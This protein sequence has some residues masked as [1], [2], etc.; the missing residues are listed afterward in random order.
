M[1]R[2]LEVESA[3]ITE[4]SSQPE[5]VSDFELTNPSSFKGEFI[6]QITHN[7][8]HTLS[9]SRSN[10]GEL[11]VGQ[12]LTYKVEA[13]GSGVGGETSVRFAANWSKETVTT[14]S[15]NLGTLGRV[16]V[17]LEPGQSVIA[18]LS[19]SAGTIKARVRYKAF[20]KGDTLVHY[21]Q[22]YNGHY[23]WFRNIQ[24]PMYVANIEN[25]IE[26]VEDIEIGY[27]S[28]FVVRL[29][30][31]KSGDL[32][33]AIDMTDIPANSFFNDTSSPIDKSPVID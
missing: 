11:E 10:G 24:I 33:Q 32:M 27:Y 13:L 18:Q 21:D 4:I 12:K 30:D 16:Q 7:K 31:K 15:I 19:A 9:S 2:V 6:G 23:F 20:L 29:I 25:S 26:V 14:D 5:I 17:T 8:T 28:R 22:Q 3:K 1:T